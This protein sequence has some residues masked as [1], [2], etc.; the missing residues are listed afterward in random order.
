MQTRS[1]ADTS[2]TTAVVMMMTL[3]MW[4]L[5]PTAGMPVLVTFCQD[6]QAVLAICQEG[7]GSVSEIAQLASC[8][9]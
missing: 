2:H 1:H 4:S 5:N 7:Q 9:R 8:K 6:G 3:H